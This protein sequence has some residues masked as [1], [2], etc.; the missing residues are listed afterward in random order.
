MPEGASLDLPGITQGTASH[1]QSKPETPEVD[2]RTPE[3]IQA[4]AEAEAAAKEEKKRLIAAKKAQPEN[5]LK[6]WLN[7]IPSDL[8]A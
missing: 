4:A 8:L 1:G 7:R 6:T 5:R 3:E 2:T